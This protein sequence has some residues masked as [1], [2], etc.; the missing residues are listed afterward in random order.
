MAKKKKKGADD[1]ESGG[2]K[3]DI[4]KIAIGAVIAAVVYT[5]VLAGGGSAEPVEAGPTTLPEPV[6]GIVLD[7]GQ[8]RVTLADDDPHFALVSMAVV[9]EE[10]ADQVAVEN[11]LPILLDAAVDE[12]SAFT[13]NEIKDPNGPENLRTAL[14][15]RADQIFN[16]EGEQVA[17]VRVVLTELIV[18]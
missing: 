15:D 16:T 12:V 17:V 2:S 7:A 3:L 13:M 14:T 10:S 9:M 18:Q 1:E 11:R 6:E 5:Q 8:V 4:K